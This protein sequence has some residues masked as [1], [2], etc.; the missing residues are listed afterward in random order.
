MDE[1]IIENIKELVL[2]P[3]DTVKDIEIFYN[4]EGDYVVS[5]TQDGQ[6]KLITIMYVD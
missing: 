6:K 3:D 5:Y 1:K 4:L 2:E